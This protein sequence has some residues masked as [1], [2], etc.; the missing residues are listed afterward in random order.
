MAQVP[1]VPLPQVSQSTVQT[2]LQDVRPPSEAFGLSSVG[3]TLTEAGHTAE[4]VSTILDAHAQQFQAI[5]NKTQADSHALTNGAAINSFVEDW[6]QNNRGV[7]AAKPE[8]LG[9]AYKQLDTIAAQG[10]EGLSP[11]AN[12]EY[13]AAIRRSVLGAQ[14]GLKTFALGQ[15]REGTNA[16]ADATAKDAV[17]QAAAHPENP[18]FT[19]NAVETVGTQAVIKGRVM[20][21]DPDGAQAHEWIKGQLGAMY[22]GQIE[23]AISS[24]DNGAATRIRDANLDTFDNAT[25]QSINRTLSVGKKSSQAN[26]DGMAVEHN[27]G[28]SPNNTAPTG[29]WDAG[30]ATFRA[31][32]QG[33]IA[34]YAG[35]GVTVTSGARTQAQN[36][37]LPNASP[38]S[39]HLQNTAWDFKPSSGTLPNVAQTL[40]N[41]LHAANIPFDQVE[42]D[43]TNGHIHVGFGPKNRNEIIDQTGKVIQGTAPAHVMAVPVVPIHADTDPDAYLLAAEPAYS[44]Y[45]QRAYPNDPSQQ[46]ASLNAMMS[47]ARRKAQ[48]IGFQ[49]KQTFDDLSTKAIGFDDM[50]TFVAANPGAATAISALP[51]KYQNALTAGMRTS[52]NTWTPEKIGQVQQLEGLK[53]QAGTNPQAFLNADIQAMDIP[54]AAKVQYIKAQQDLRGK[55]G[56]QVQADNVAVTA[57]TRSPVGV[58][59]VAGLGLDAKSRKDNPDVQQHYNQF[60]GA[61][62]Q[63]VDAYTAAHGKPPASG[64]KEMNAIINQVSATVGAK[65]GNPWLFGLGGSPGTPAFQVPADYTAKAQAFAKSQGRNITDSEIANAYQRAKARANVQH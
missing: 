43:S 10:T 27:T 21:W 51:A 15:W 13:Q 42:V 11:A 50:S 2:P 32:P 37:A 53:A 12:V 39:E 30:V 55:V 57:L 24:G 23:N 28:V 60:I 20:G 63:Q 3:Q 34:Q 41:N 35:V 1:G 18:D 4:Q 58:Q 47:A 26:A 22:K 5:T 49:Q 7:N 25:L 46:E 65:A 38:T 8:A 31:D 17:D 14:S 64:S 16:V 48:L 29:R 56:K 33:T 52:A 6:Q 45:V 40:A 9:D 19:A 61:L 62:S 36:S 44:D 54:P 59:A